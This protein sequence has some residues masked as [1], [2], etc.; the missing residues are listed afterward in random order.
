MSEHPYSSDLHMHSTAS[1]GVYDP[2]KLMNLAADN[3]LT[4]V[5]LTDHDTVSGVKE[6]QKT[7]EKRGLI[8]IPGIEFST[9]EGG[10]SVHILGYGYDIDNQAFLKALEE[11]RKMREDRLEKMVKK[12]AAHGVPLTREDV[13]AHV[14]GSVIAR[15][16]V[17]QAMV[18]KGYVQSVKDAFDRYLAEGK[19]CYVAKAKEWSPEEAIE[20]I[21]NAGGYA[22]V[23]HPGHYDLDDRIEQ[24]VKDFGLDGVEVYHRD[25]DENQVKRYEEIVQDIENKL[26]NDL[27]ITGGSDFHSPDYGRD[28]EELGVTKLADHFA[29][30]LVNLCEKT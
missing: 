19:P 29:E 8:F 13:M 18:E 7:A 4:I 3:G 14:D 20:I 28:K 23:A 11:Q 2:A 27:L 24:W 5:S 6:A 17:G 15:P 26:G 21:H 12:C 30:R 9:K 22:I 1:D 16:H 25:H 10:E